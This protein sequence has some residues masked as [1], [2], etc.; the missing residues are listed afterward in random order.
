MIIP[1][2]IY[3]EIIEE[4]LDDFI[5]TGFVEYP[6][7]RIF[8]GYIKLRLNLAKIHTYDLW[9]FNYVSNLTNFSYW[10]VEE[11]PNKKYYM[12]FIKNNSFFC[13]DEVNFCINQQAI[14]LTRQPPLLYLVSKSSVED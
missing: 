6:N 14:Y 5:Y 1:V 3:E 4:A 8:D 7:Y 2:Q 11:F 12:L 9:L 13:N 10:R